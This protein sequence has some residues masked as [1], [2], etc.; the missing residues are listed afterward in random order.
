LHHH[1][2]ITSTD[3]ADPSSTGVVSVLLQRAGRS[4]SDAIHAKRRALFGSFV[5][6]WSAEP[7]IRVRNKTL[8]LA[9]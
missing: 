2:P 8:T 1:G 6:G 4:P 3:A 9:R 5:E 7:P